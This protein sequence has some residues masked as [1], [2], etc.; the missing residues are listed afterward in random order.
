MDA[1]KHVQV[2]EL[3]GHETAAATLLTL[4]SCC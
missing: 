1:E 3:G 4:S 2:Q